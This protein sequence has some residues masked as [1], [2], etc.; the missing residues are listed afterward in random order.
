MEDLVRVD[1]YEVIYNDEDDRGAAKKDGDAVEIGVGYHRVGAMWK[2]TGFGLRFGVY[3]GGIGPSTASE[4]AR[5]SVAKR[6]PID[7]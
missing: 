4:L 7:I 3:G 6:K 5:A 2:T 1:F